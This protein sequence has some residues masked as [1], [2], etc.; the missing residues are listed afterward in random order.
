MITTVL[1][2]DE[3]RALIEH[4]LDRLDEESYSAMFRVMSPRVCRYF[5]LRGCSRDMAEDLTQEVMFA[6]Y[7]QIGRLRNRGLFR[8][9]L[10]QIARNA[11]LQHRRQE[12]RRVQT[13]ELDNLDETMYAVSEDPVEAF[14]LAEWLQCLRP[15]E[16]ELM[17]LRYVEGFEYHELATILNMPAGTV[18]W[19]V[20]QLKK[21][22]ANRF[23]NRPS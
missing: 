4:F 6:V 19:K 18:Q 23:G 12:H 20:F 5:R 17:V 7:T 22:L 9:W 1:D 16:R 15:E 13:A 14:Y 8:A 3:S 11:W 10:F 2:L 21:T